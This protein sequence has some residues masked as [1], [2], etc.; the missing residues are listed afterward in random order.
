MS[1]KL[2]QRHTAAGLYIVSVFTAFLSAAG[3]VAFA[4]EPDVHHA[5]AAM[6]SFSMSCPAR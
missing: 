2:L 5:N 4:Q 6:Q 1:R 3:L